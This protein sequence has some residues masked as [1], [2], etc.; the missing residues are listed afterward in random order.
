MPFNKLSNKKIILAS[1]SPRRQQFL[2]DL[3]VNFE[4]KLREVDESY[5]SN[6]KGKDIA[7]FISEK[8]SSAFND[9]IDNEVLIT[10]DTIVWVNDKAL[11]KP[12]DRIDAI[13]MLKELSG[14]MHEVISAFTLKTNKYT[15]S[16]YSSTKVFFNELIQE[17]IEYYVDNFKPF[18]KAGSYGI[19]EWIGLIGINKI[20][21]SYNN[22]V[23]L[24]VDMVYKAL[25]NIK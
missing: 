17:E 2:K 9:L 7:V 19:Q 13:N 3:G 25:L 15:I 6:L 23:G 14:N 22:V 11:G 10:S 12:K 24:P 16:D 18:D 1:G 21:G 5:P 4:I 8:K 20:E